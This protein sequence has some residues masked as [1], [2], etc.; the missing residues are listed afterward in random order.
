MPTSV[1]SRS[2]PAR[3]EDD[4][5]SESELVM[6]DADAEEFS[7]SEPGESPMSTVMSSL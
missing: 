7:G 2:S 6:A 1:A 4:S 3:G 5:E